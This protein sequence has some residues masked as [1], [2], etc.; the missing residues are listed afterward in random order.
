MNLTGYEID[1]TNQSDNF[2]YLDENIEEDMSVSKIVYY[3]LSNPR[4]DEMTALK[5]VEAFLKYFY[6]N[7]DWRLKIDGVDEDNTLLL[8]WVLNE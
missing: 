6:M 2:W 8:K 1:Y 5:S 3:L 4:E 7:H